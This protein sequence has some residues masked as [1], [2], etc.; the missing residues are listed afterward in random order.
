MLPNPLHPAFIHFAITFLVVAIIAAIASLFYFR[1]GLMVATAVLFLIGSG[2]TYLATIGGQKAGKQIIAIHP[3][4]RGDVDKHQI[5]GYKL[6]LASV[7]TTGFA[8]LTLY[9]CSDENNK[10]NKV[11]RLSTV[12]SSFF[13]TFLLIE[14]GESGAKIIYED[15]VGIYPTGSTE[16]H[17][18]PK[19][20]PGHE[21]PS[22]AILKQETLTLK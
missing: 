10:L 2:T 15:I 16:P 14:T 22:A 4:V 3:E 1:K 21:K 20:H 11:L 13:V 18:A 12:L 17:K 6:L 5:E 7:I 9:L 8:F 19:D